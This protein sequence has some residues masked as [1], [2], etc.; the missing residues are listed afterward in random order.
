MEKSLAT[1][2]GPTWPG[3]H[4]FT[5]Q[6]AGGYSQGP[7]R[8][9]NLG[10]HCGDNPIHV[11]QNRALLRSHLPNTPHWV[12]QVH[13]TDLYY[14]TGAGA[15]E[16]A[17]HDAPRADAMWTDQKNTVLAI[18]TADCLPVVITDH[19]AQVIGVA[20]A[21]W[22]GLAGGV[23]QRLF[24]QL[25][26]QCDSSAQWRA[27]IGPAISQAHFEVGA[28]VYET[29]LHVNT[30]LAAYFIYDQASQRYWADLPRIARYLLNQCD[31]TMQVH[32]SHACTYAETENYY[33]YRRHNL[34]GRIAT[35]AWLG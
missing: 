18:L 30:D 29:F 16:A 13:G 35:I 1:L 21:G 20:H 7:W 31:S 5:T 27:W 6:I 34:T 12:Q 32:V 19:R 11:A 3:V 26:S 28:E 24:T 33:S 10:Q 8:G 17:W 14:A 25:Q 22:R 4:Y 9:L 23:L 15:H 2:T